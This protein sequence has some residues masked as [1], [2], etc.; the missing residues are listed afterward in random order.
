MIQNDFGKI[1]DLRDDIK[2]KS[3]LYD[4]VIA[5]LRLYCFIQEDQNGK[6]EGHK[7]RY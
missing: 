7:K 2:F 1:R 5:I 6:A 3:L 4:R